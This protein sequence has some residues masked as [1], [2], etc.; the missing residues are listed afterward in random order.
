M[1]IRDFTPHL[2]AT[3][4]ACFLTGIA[5]TTGCDGGSTTTPGKT[6]TSAPIGLSVEPETLDM[7]DLVPEIAVTKQVT[8][9]NH[10]AAPIT[11]LRA[12]ADCACTTPSWPMEPIEP[13]ESVETDITITAG[14]KQ[15]ITL[16]KRVTFDVAGG[17][18][19]F[20]NV[21][22][23][24]GLFI[25]YAPE[26]LQA[27]ADEVDPAKVASAESTITLNSADGVAFRILSI[28]PDIAAADVTVSA[29]THEVRVDW[30]KWRAASKPIKLSIVTDHPKSPP[31][32][33]LIRRHNAGGVS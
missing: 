6:P 12:I 29:V 8:L 32:V 13:G 15:G 4:C 5:A 22:G 26:Y 9:T 25:S 20:L 30:S 21:V 3:F 7:G 23:K 33:T 2:C 24:V 11:I 10:T 14:L 16:T 18:P 31:L 17:E 27:P 19:V 1:L 28:E